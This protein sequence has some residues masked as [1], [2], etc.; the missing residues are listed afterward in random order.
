M[1]KIDILSRWPDFDQERLDNKRQT[2]FKMRP[3]Q[4]YRVDK[5]DK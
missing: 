4:L 2:I 5:E 3:I 1:R